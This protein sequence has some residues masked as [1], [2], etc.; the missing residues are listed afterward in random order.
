MEETKGFE[1]TLTILKW[2][3]KKNHIVSVTHARQR[4]KD[5]G[6]K[7]FMRIYAGWDLVHRKREETEKEKVHEMNENSCH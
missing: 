1:F 6:K 3:Q 2:N 4:H 5:L 7:I